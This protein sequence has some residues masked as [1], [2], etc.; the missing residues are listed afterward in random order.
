LGRAEVILAD[1]H[2]V[3]WLAFEP[4]QLSANALKA[5]TEAR[6][7]FGGVAVADISLWE[8]ATAVHRGKVELET[9]LSEFLRSVE[10]TYRVLPINGEI[11]E[12]GRLFSKAYPR[13]PADRL[14]GATAI[15][16]GLQLVT[17]DGP[18]RASGEVPVVW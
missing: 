14:I 7:K 5:L 18:I 12:R 1:T 16:H 10:E 11:A 2:V 17:R 4:D 15:V 8:I 13:D 3:L 6:E 9:E